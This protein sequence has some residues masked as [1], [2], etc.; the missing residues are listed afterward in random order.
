MVKWIKPLVLANFPMRVCLL[1]GFS[2]VQPSA[3]LWTVACQASLSMRFSRQ[4]YWNELLHPPP[5]DLP[6][7][8]IEPASLLSP[9]L[10][11]RFFSS[12][13]IWE[14]QSSHRPPTKLDLDIPSA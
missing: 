6:N 14:A 11:G 8:G 3:T 12:S 2:H 5:G 10:V 4:E 1:S 9:D 7:P 13:A